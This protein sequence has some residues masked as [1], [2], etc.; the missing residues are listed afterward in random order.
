MTA[1]P[2]QSP[3]EPRM[4]VKNEATSG[5][6][7]V[8]AAVILVIGIIAAIWYFQSSEGS[9]PSSSDVTITIDPN[10]DPGTGTTIYP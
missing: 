1:N 9:N 5:T 2:D 4:V 8:V 7:M 6:G 3:V 10:A